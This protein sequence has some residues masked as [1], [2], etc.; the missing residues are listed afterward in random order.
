MISIESKTLKELKNGNHTA[1]EEI[2]NRYSKQ[3]YLFALSY[4]KSEVSAEDIV[5][6]VFIKIWNN[7]MAIKTDTSFQSYLFTITL[8]SVRKYFNQLS[9]LNELKH[10]ILF[11]SSGFK[12][13]FDDRSEYQFM[14]DKLDEFISLMPEKRREVFIKKKI[15]EKTLKEISE[16]LSITTKTVEY[17]ITEAMRFLKSEFEKLHIQGLIFFSLFIRQ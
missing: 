8:N 9:R 3:L 17:H 12:A 2:F 6:E 13:D 14:L 16:E 1:F 7:R 15:E 11:D 10:D 4:L 5:Q